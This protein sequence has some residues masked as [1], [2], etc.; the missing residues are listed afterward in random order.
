[1][2]D[3]M[4]WYTG[5]TI[6]D[7]L[8]VIGFVFAAVIFLS[9]LKGTAHYGGRF[10]G[11]GGG[12]KL[13][14]KPGWVL[15]EIPALIA[16]PI[17]YFL[18]T[19]AFEA[20]PLF[21][22]C[23]WIMHYTNRALITPLLMRVQP[24]TKSSFDISVVVLGWITLALHSYL[25]AAFISELGDFYTTEW[26]TDPR[27]ITGLVIYLIGFTLNV[28]S[29]SILRNLRSKNPRPDEPRYKIPYGGAFK[30]VTCPQYLGEITAFVG[31]AIMTWN[32]GAVFVIAI[33]VANLVPRAL[34]THRW[35]NKHFSDYP[36]ERKAI[37][38][39]LL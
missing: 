8:L 24:G 4:S 29:D 37:V 14:S 3:H 16:F 1:M 2:G 13:G 30:W 33:T 10:G 7:A 23:I 28:R 38:P 9:S 25:N 22:F 34:Y 18:G 31:F 11:R 26:F 36:K 15:M 32:L 19:N 6:Y 17:I 27:F 39:Y 35:F 21:F 20:V 12:F 5:N